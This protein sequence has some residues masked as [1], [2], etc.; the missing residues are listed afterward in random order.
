[1]DKNKIIKFNVY[2]LPYKTGI[3]VEISKTFYHEKEAR[4]ILTELIEKE[5]FTAK[6][7]F[8]NKFL[9]K[10]KLKKYGFLKKDED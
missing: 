6:A 5:E 1:M 10:A 3:A 2:T 7:C 8:N 4:E 9:A